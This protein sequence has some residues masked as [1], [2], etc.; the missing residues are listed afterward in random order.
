MTKKTKP[1]YRGVKKCS[2]PVSYNEN[3]TY[4]WV[5]T[6]DNNI[7]EYAEI[8][9]AFSHLIKTSLEYNYE[10]TYKYYD[11]LK[12]SIKIETVAMHSHNFN[13]VIE[14]LY[15]YPES[16]NI[17]ENDKDNYSASELAFLKKLQ[18][19]LLLMGLKDKS[20]S[21]DMI[22][23][24]RKYKN[25]LNSKKYFKELVK[26]ERKE[27]LERANNKK[28][29]TYHEAGYFMASDNILDAILNK[30]KNTR[31][32]RQYS[33]STSRIKERYFILDNDYNYKALIEITDENIIPFKDLKVPVKEYRLNSAK[34][35][36][37][38]KEELFDYF[39]EDNTEEFTEDSLISIATFKII[40]KY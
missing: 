37:E 33:Y 26:L 20:D 12:N 35:L 4:K 17:P 13:D 27:T 14:T 8:Y 3:D 30:E 2:L 15:Y 22:N 21:K 11:A 1:N 6:E 39:K 7:F 9:E 28:V 38:Y 23:L 24:H 19:Y 18:N 25:E 40:E 16:F 32:F 29:R 34:S 10:I 31:I 5:F 36:L